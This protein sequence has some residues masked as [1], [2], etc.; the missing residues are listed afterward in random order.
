M[1]WWFWAW[2][3]FVFLLILLPL[4]YGW[5]YRG[6]GAPYPRYRY[7]GRPGRIVELEEVDPPRRR[8]PE[9]EPARS[10]WGLAGDLLW[11]AVIGA[12]IW[13]IVWAWV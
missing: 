10:G 9:R 4:G 11:L 5:G 6:W 8:P 1:W 12:I 13:L 3:V 7:R 2:I